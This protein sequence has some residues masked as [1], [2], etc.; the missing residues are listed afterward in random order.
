MNHFKKSILFVAILLAL[1]SAISGV[2]TYG[3]RHSPA[4]PFSKV[5]KLMAHE[6][7]P[8][9]MIFGASTAWVNFNPDIISRT[10]GL[11]VFNMGLDGTPMPEYRGLA[12]E[13]ILYA[14]KCKCI[15]FAIGITEFSVREGLYQPYKFYAYMGN[16]NI[17]N[18]FFDLQPGFAWRMRYVPFYNLTAYTVPFY[19]GVEAG[20]LASA[21]KTPWTGE[22]NGYFPMDNIW[23]KIQEQKNQEA[24]ETREVI[25]DKRLNMFREFTSMCSDSGFIVVTVM[26]PIQKDGQRLIRN[27]PEVKETIAKSVPPQSHFLDYTINELCNDKIYFYNNTHLNQTG[28]DRFSR[29]FSEDFRKLMAS[30]RHHSCSRHRN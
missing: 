10:T 26:T 25:D 20:W 27:I 9:M 2:I 7:D 17:Y 30:D 12:R 8:E 6:I 28:A 13:F 23:D 22:K 24:Q 1:L 18:A 14:K 11:S 21:G 19:Q 15:V 29:I 3:A 16:D 5:N 4:V